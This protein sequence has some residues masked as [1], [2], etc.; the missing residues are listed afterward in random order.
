M[1]G[2]HGCP[3]RHP[4]SLHLRVRVFDRVAVRTWLDQGTD[5]VG[6]PA[7][8]RFTIVLA[9]RDTGGVMV[10]IQSTGVKRDEPANS[11]RSQGL[12]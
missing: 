3:H 2:N 6:K 12:D 1:R 5:V 8:S 4:T 10:N 11:E 7:R 9:W